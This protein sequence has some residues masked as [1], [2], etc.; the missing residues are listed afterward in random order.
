MKKNSLVFSF[1]LIAILAINSNVK[2]IGIS[3]ARWPNG[4]LEF[5]CSFNSNMGYTLYRPSS[6]RY[7]IFSVSD[8]AGMTGTITGFSTSSGV[9]YQNNKSILIDWQ[10][11]EL[12]SLSSITAS[13]NIQS[14]TSWDCPAEP[15]GSRYLA[16]LV[17]HNEAFESGS[18]IVAGVAAVSQIAFHRNY[19]PRTYLQSLSTSE[20]AVNLGLQFE[21][22]KTSWFSKYI[23]R[24]YNGT[25]PWFAYGIDWDGDGQT[26]QSGTAIFDEEPVPHSKYPNI[27]TW[28]SGIQV[29]TIALGH[30]YNSAGNYTATITLSDAMETTTLEIPIEV[31]PEPATLALLGLGGLFL[32]KHKT[33]I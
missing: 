2:G 24:D 32:R 30:I 23:D 14:P 16:D 6:R 7:S 19:A 28:T 33:I 17:C 13:I 10:S 18:G 4:L 1:M 9:E 11:E 12:M 27:F 5:N 25:N 8:A 3:P 26:D 20:L 21:D 15:G 29:S 22:K 31:V